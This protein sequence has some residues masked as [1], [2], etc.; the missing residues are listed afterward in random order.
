[1]S[2]CRAETCSG[3]SSLRLT[4]RA[5]HLYS[6]LE[7]AKHLVLNGGSKQH[8]FLSCSAGPIQ[9]VQHVQANDLD[10]VKQSRRSVGPVSIGPRQVSDLATLGAFRTL[11]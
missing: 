1:M 8:V 2:R 4:S 9:G 10:L 7:R 6:K 5:K 11:A 3:S